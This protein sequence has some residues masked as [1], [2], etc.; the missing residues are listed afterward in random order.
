MPLTSK[1]LNAIFLLLIFT[2][3][4]IGDKILLWPF[5]YYSHIKEFTHI[6]EGLHKNGHVIHLVLPPSLP[7]IQ[8]FRDD[9]KL[10]VI[11]YKVKEPDF[12]SQ[13]ADEVID[14]IVGL[15]PIEDFRQNVEGFTQVKEKEG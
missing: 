13:T 4:A 14:A 12:H 10:K 3:K 5:P 11:E 15:S 9:P 8:Q 7:Q 2:E 1:F 6:S